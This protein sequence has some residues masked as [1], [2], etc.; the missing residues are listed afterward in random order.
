MTLPKRKT[1]RASEL[2]RFH[3]RGFL[4]QKRHGCPGKNN[5]HGRL[6][7]GISATTIS[8]FIG[9][10]LA[11]HDEVI[12]RQDARFDHGTHRELPKRNCHR[13]GKLLGV[14]MSSCAISW[15]RRRCRQRRHPRR[16]CS[17]CADRRGVLYVESNRQR[18]RLLGISFRCN[19]HA[20]APQCVGHGGR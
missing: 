18:A 13:D 20:S 5:V 16:G 19:P 14:D 10:G 6:P 2:H 3:G 15:A 9:G 17:G 4:V 12:A 8:P 11:L 7:P 1:S